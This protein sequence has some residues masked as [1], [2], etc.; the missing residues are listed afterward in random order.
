MPVNRTGTEISGPGGGAIRILDEGGVLRNWE[1]I[2][3]LVGLLRARAPKV[4]K[5]FDEIDMEYKE[6]EEGEK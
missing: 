1:M 3:R 6:I 2:R 5:Q 4:G